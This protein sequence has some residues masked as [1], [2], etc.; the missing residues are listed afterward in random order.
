MKHFSLLKKIHPDGFIKAYDL[1]WYFV[2]ASIFQ[3]ESECEWDKVRELNEELARIAENVNHDDGNYMPLIWFKLADKKEGN[4]ADG[5]IHLELK[6]LT[7]SNK[8]KIKELMPSV[9]L[10][11]NQISV[12]RS[13]LSQLVNI[14]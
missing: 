8:T 9:K 5:K 6:G 13:S 11:L 10:D 12:E 2:K 4:D 1:S 7:E 3:D 14:L